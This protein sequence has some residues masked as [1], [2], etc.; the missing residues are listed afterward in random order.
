MTSEITTRLF[1]IV[2][3]GG[4]QLWIPEEKLTAFDSQYKAARAD[5]GLM[6]YDGQR[7]NPADVVGVFSADA[8]EEATRRKN[9]QWSCQHGNWH[10]RGEKCLCVPKERSTWNAR[11]SEAINACGKCQNGWVFTERGAKRCE[12]CSQ[13]FEANGTD[14]KKPREARAG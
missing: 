10:D 5:G 11:L 13:F 8:M 6:R 4:V 1:C 2:I 12:C 7:I 14:P 3:R 9:G